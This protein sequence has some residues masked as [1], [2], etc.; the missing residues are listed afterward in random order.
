MASASDSLK[1]RY[2]E[3]IGRQNLKTIHNIYRSKSRFYVELEMVPKQTS[4]M[5]HPTKRSPM[6]GLV[7]KKASQWI[8]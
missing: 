5:L 4:V 7:L 3:E 2:I 6:S 8:N 1:R